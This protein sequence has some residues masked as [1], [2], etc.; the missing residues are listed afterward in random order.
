[1][2]KEELIIL[3][4]GRYGSRRYR[5]DYWTDGRTKG[6]SKHAAPGFPKTEDGSI[7]GVAKL[8]MRG[9]IAKGACY[10]RLTGRYIWTV[11]RGDKVPGTRLY[12]PV[13]TKGEA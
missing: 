4:D 12:T 1:M 9:V 8:A 5:T 6:P 3:A 2:S 10:D 13:I 7:N 11:Q